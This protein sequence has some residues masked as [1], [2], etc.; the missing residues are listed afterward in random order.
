M[1]RASSCYEPEVGRC[2][3]LPTFPCPGFMASLMAPD[4]LA[5][6]W[7]SGHPRLIALG[8][9]SGGGPGR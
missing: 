6:S 3:V 5:V 4:F 9:S 2:V 1:R 8:L 7:A